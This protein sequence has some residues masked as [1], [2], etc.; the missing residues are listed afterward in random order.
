MNSG[1]LPLL[2]LCG[3]VGIALSR[4]GWSEAWWGVGGAV[5]AALLAFVAPVRFDTPE[6]LLAALWASVI[7]TAALAYVPQGWSTRWAVP[8][9]INGGLWSGAFAGASDMGVSFVLAL[10]PLLLFLPG[11]WITERG[12]AMGL[13]VAASW[14]IAIGSLSLFVSQLPTPGYKADHMK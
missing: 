2:L 13:K 5:V 8:T 1:V 9:A 6:A 4:A 3:A 10:A 11:R 14:V 12:G 7:I